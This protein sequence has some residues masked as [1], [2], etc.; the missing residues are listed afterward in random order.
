MGLRQGLVLAVLL[1]LLAG[2]AWDI[3][4]DHMEELQGQDV[5][6]AV[7]KLGYPHSEITLG[8]QKHYVWHRREVGSRRVP[9]YETKRVSSYG[10]DGISFDTYST[11][12]YEH[13][14]YDYECTLR[15]FVDEQERIVSWKVAGTQGAC[16]AFAWWL[17]N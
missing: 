10:S 9:R 8:G 4:D 16:W 17:S 1:P 13:V 15:I 14:P 11:T 3:V 7:A 6:R 2:C 12:T 5:G